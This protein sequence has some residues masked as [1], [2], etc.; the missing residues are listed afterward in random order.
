MPT[1]GGKTY[2]AKFD[3]IK[4]SAPLLK[5]FVA[6]TADASNEHRSNM[7]YCLGDFTPQLR[8]DAFHKSGAANRIKIGASLKKHLKQLVVID[9]CQDM[10]AIEDIYGFV[11]TSCV[12]M[13]DAK[14]VPAFYE[15]EAFTNF[16]VKQV[17]GVA[18]FDALV[19]KAGKKLNLKKPKNVAV[20]RDVITEGLF[21]SPAK[22]Q[23]MAD[24]LAK[25]GMFG[26]L[27]V[28]RDV[29][30]ELKKHKLV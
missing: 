20:L 13:L 21:G 4:T 30:K 3:Q 16:H 6:F 17:T 7:F 15:S 25:T 1:F 14:G 11:K 5:A 24:K 8:Y 9:N 27:G 10:D 22:A 19:T 23:A 26:S 28:T 12:K 29:F 18:N 2:P